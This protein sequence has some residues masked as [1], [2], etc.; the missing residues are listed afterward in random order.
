ML[1]VC[2]SRNMQ[3]ERIAHLNRWL[4]E[5]ENHVKSDPLLNRRMEVVLLSF[6]QVGQQ[7]L[8]GFVSP[9]HFTA[10]TLSANGVAPISPAIRLALECI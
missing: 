3:G 6:G 1:V 4:S 8:E 5:F 7:W 2:N 9:C 10:P